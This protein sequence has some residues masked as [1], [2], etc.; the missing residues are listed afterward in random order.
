MRTGR[1][2]PVLFTRGA[3]LLNMVEGYRFPG[4]PNIDSVM[5]SAR[6]NDP[7]SATLGIGPT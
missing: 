6:N 7:N 3:P 4:A 5:S 1:P 2:G